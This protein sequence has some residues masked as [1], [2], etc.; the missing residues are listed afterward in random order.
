MN[1]I[2]IKTGDRVYFTFHSIPSILGE[3]ILTP[4]NLGD[5]WVVRAD[6]E[7]GDCI[8]RINPTSA[9]LITIVV[10]YKKQEGIKSEDY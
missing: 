5:Y 8:I 1:D 2:S 6:K 7:Y 4:S 10:V 3:I 9:D